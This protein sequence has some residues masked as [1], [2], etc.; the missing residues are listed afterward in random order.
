M[1]HIYVNPNPSGKRVGDCTIRAI[2][3][4]LD[5]SWDS[6]YAEL[7]LYGYSMKDMP[8]SN[9]VWD[10]L[11][12]DNGFKRYAIPDHCPECYTVK[13]FCRDNPEGLYVLGIG[14]HVVTVKNGNYM[15]A[16]DSGEEVVI[17]FYRKEM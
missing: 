7:A 2:S 3:I 14:N 5:R 1:G 11:L 13:D 16:W 9:A 17:Y 6:V 10:A 4:A 15:D 8:S 12:R